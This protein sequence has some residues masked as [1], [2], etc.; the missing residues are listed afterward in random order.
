VLASVGSG[1]GVASVGSVVWTA[2][3]LADLLTALAVVMT[4]RVVET[5]PSASVGARLARVVLWVSVPEK[6]LDEVF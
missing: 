1:R 4:G 3:T 5:T 2:T 6:V